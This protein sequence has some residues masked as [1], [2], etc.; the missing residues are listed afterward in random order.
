[1]GFELGQRYVGE[2][3][4]VF[5]I[6]ELSANH[7]GSLDTA[8]RTIE[9]AAKTG[10]DAIKLQTYTPDTLT[11]NSR[12][13]DFVVRTN[14][15]W[16]GRTLHDLYA[17]AMTPWEWH[18]ELFAC[19]RACGLICFST[20][21]DVTAVELLEH[22]G[23]PAHKVASFE[24]VDLPLVER[25]ARTNKPMIMS[26]GMASLGEIEAAVRVCKQAGNE[27]IALLRCV[28]AYPAAPEDMQLKSIDVLA[29]FGV[30]VGLSDHTLDDT[31]AI[32]AVARGACIVEK[33]FILDRSVGGPDSFF[34]LEPAQM[35]SLVKSVRAAQRSMGG[36]AFGPSSSERASLAFR[37]SLYVAADLKQGEVLTCDHVRSV[38]PAHGLP[39][40]FLPQVLGRK[41]QRDL[42]L[43]SP[44]SL[45]DVGSNPTTDARLALRRATPADS[46]HLLRWR[47]DPLTRQMSLTQHEVTPEEHQRWLHASLTG[48]SRSLFIAVDDEVPVGTVRLEHPSNGAAEV[49]LT[50]APEARGRGLG[51]QLLRLAER[52]ALQ[53]GALTLLARILPDNARSVLAFKRAGFYGFAERDG[54]PRTLWCE[55]RIAP[56]A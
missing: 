6:A 55:R 9:A 24:L 27:Q 42:Q 56:Y 22:L 49:S 51:S 31:A 23:A 12:A 21:F 13:P 25:I 11:L 53:L 16:A 46:E 35:A 2:G 43:G 14:N 8:L 15:Q 37:R 33:H 45:A 32:A 52:E 4:P 44:L 41:A 50:V 19:A 40:S 30:L 26:T 18:A 38:R 3:A 5:V 10:V 28:S 36:P 1:M 34:S 48:T 29:S 20:P 39:A 7:G 47:N 17:E 54:N